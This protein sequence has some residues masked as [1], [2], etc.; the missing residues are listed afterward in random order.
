MLAAV[1]ALADDKW[2][3]IPCACIELKPGETA[4][5]AAELEAF[6][7]ARLASFK[8]PRRFVFRELPKTATGKIQ[9]FQL[10]Q[11]LRGG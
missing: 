7:R 8:V 2:G 6:C 9:K 5:A 4:P 10:R 11:A 3:E 1:V